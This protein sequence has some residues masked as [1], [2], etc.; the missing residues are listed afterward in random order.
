MS[1]GEHEEVDW[2]RLLDWV[3]QADGQPKLGRVAS[4]RLWVEDRWM[5]L[6]D[7]VSR[8]WGELR[9]PMC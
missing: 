4:L 3:L 5:G 8:A 6:V 2:D 1:G 9:R 7:R